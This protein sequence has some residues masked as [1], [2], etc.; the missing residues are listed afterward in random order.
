MNGENRVSSRGCQGIARRATFTGMASTSARNLGIISA[1]PD[2]VLP[3]DKSLTHRALVLAA[4]A[5]GESVLHH[6]L[7]S[8]ETR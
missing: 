2:I 5:N 1:G 7:T 3:G 6:P 4:L 8:L